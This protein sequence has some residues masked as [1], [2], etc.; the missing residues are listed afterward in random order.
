MYRSQSADSVQFYH[1]YPPDRLRLFAIFG[2]MM[3]SQRLGRRW[4]RVAP[5]LTFAVLVAID[6]RSPHPIGY[7][8]I[9]FIARPGQP[10]WA[11][12]GFL[13]SEAYR[14]RG[15]GSLLAVSMYEYCLRW[16]VRRGGGTVQSANSPSR[17]I[18]E[19]FGFRLHPSSEVDRFAPQLEN[20]EAIED[21]EQVM[22]RVQGWLAA[23]SE[24]APTAPK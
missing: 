9:R 10:L 17:R 22:A 18:V 13:V 16:G 8:T 7:A 6:P 2:W 24:R 19:R 4:L 15:I 3:V 20:L 23:R 1:P 11:R 5:N 21:L 14:G 12:F